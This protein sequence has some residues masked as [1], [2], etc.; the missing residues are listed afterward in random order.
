MPKLGPDKKFKSEKNF[1][2]CQK[3]AHLFEIRVFRKYAIN[4]RRFLKKSAKFS[5]FL[6]FVQEIFNIF[7]PKNSNIFSLPEAAKK[8]CWSAE[9]EKLNFSEFFAFFRVFRFRD[10]L[11][12]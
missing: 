2:F 1:T 6:V 4:S 9:I 7:L 11:I 12:F 3:F 10:F 8:S 5:R